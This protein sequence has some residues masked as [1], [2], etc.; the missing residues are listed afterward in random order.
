MLKWVWQ[1]TNDMPS[2][3]KYTAINLRLM[4]LLNQNWLGAQIDFRD[5]SI[6]CPI[7]CVQAFRS[8]IEALSLQILRTQTMDISTELEAFQ[9]FSISFAHMVIKICGYQYV[10]LWWIGFSGMV[11][12]KKIRKYWSPQYFAVNIQKKNAQ[13]PSGSIK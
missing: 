10:E 5:S 11:G 2:G 3:W 1:Q 7:Y 8:S 13:P 12:T 4:Y 9:S 6:Y